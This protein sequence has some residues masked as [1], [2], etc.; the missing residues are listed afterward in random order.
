MAANYFDTVIAHR[1]KSVRLGNS[2]IANAHGAA[3]QAAARTAASALVSAVNDQVDGIFE[4]RQANS[5]F[6]PFGNFPHQAGLQKVDRASGE[7]LRANFA[8][9]PNI[10][11]FAGHPDVPGRADTNPS[12]PALGWVQAIE[13]L[14][15]GI[16]VA[17]KWNEAGRKAITNANYRFYSPNWLLRKVSGGIQPVRLLSI[18]LTNNPLIP[19]RAISN[20]KPMIPKTISPADTT[21]LD[22]LRRQLPGVSA[23]TLNLI[24]ALRH[25]APV[26]SDPATGKPAVPDA[27][28]VIALQT[29]RRAALA[30][31][32]NALIRELPS[33]D[34][35]SR[36]GIAQRRVPELFSR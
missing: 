1:M 28:A 36:F 11:I 4:L 34:Y 26:L 35:D 25:P 24:L 33:A 17:V 9:H 15:D 20:D 3:I 18:G 12:A 23:K 2:R 13:V 29:A 27:N 10:P 32:L 21:E 7:I 5:L 30:D 14:A 16:S 8:T 31:V 6:L 22:A 19:V